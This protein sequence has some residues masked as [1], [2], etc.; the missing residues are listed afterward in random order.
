[1]PR[2]KASSD[3]FELFNSEGGKLRKKDLFAYY[4]DVE[5][6]PLKKVPSMSDKKEDILEFLFKCVSHKLQV[7]KEDLLKVWNDLESRNKLILDALE[8]IKK[9][10]ESDI[11]QSATHRARAYIN[12]IK[13]VKK[14]NVPLLS[15]QQ[16][17][18]ISGIGKGIASRVD[19][20]MRSGKLRPKEERIQSIIDRQSATEQFLKVWGVKP[21]DANEFFNKGK[22]NLDDL[23]ESEKLAEDSQ[24]ESLLN[25]VQRVGLMYFDDLQLKI[26]RADAEE[27]AKKVKK[28]IRKLFS[29][30]EVEL[31]GDYRRK[32]DDM[33]VIEILI[34]IDLSSQRGAAGN[35]AKKLLSDGIALEIPYI[36][37]QKLMGVAKGLDGRAKRFDITITD[38]SDFGL[39]LLFCTGPDTFLKEVKMM[40]GQQDF[41]LTNK[42]FHKIAK[43]DE[44]DEKIDAR[45]DQD[46]FD[47]LGMKYIEPENR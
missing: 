27:I 26:S 19:E 16:A 3:E 46:I 22:K 13:A 37:P 17:M 9:E 24:K 25:L 40:A 6:G 39:G 5:N 12:A 4:R 28:D 41:R 10:H 7:T 44:P 47:K 30:A 34:G 8:E 33:N 18:K 20:V 14:L 23:R 29:D 38:L 31:C 42:G 36:K 2:K 1:M 35:I 43:T 21:K 45:R 11:D 15:G 32:K